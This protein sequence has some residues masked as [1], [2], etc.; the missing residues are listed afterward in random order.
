MEKIISGI[1]Q[2]GIGNPNVLEATDWYREYF[3]MDIKVFDDAATADLMLPYTGGKPHDRRAILTLS[4][5]GG[6]G[7]EIW[8]YTS[9]TPV[10]ADFELQLGDLGINCCKIKSVDVAETYEQFNMA[11]LDVLTSLKE[12]PAGDLNFFVK[13][14]NGNI[15][16]VVKGLGWFKKNERK[17]TGGVSGAVIGSSD[18]DK[19]FS[20]Y[21][22]ILGYDEIVYDV[23]DTF[24]DLD[25]IPGGDL[26]FRRVLLRHSK[27]RDG[28]F[29]KLFGPTEI[30]LVQVLDKRR[31][32]KKI[33]EDRYWGDLGFIH[34][35]FDVQGMDALKA[36]C[37]SKGFPFTV[38]SANSFDMGDAAG[39]FT[40]IEDPDGTW[41][42]FVETHKVPVA[43]KLGLFID[44]TK[45]DPK[46]P[47]PNWMLRA[48][49]INRMKG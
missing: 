48:F 1:Q 31:T 17:T 27:L 30:E 25:G 26:K 39:R 9:R 18:I 3:G 14:L 8:Q 33:F 5:R 47:L 32:P 10:A 21:Q 37:E 20:L 46:K 36:E 15:F 45:R 6:G 43:K 42:E 29:S 23:S 49:S 35:C 38:D 19:S 40:Y 16:N 28:G 41:I 4:M 7:F 2:I 22:D 34:L 13:D 11:G 44:M 24:N 12:N